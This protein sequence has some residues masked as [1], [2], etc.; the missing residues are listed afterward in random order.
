M[1]LNTIVLNNWEK[2]IDLALKTGK[3]RFGGCTFVCDI[4]A[5]KKIIDMIRKGQYK[6]AYNFAY[7]L[8]THA[9]EQIPMTIWSFLDTHEDN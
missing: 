7:D 4:F 9:R 3:G 1:K 8:D 5:Y 6:K 2:N